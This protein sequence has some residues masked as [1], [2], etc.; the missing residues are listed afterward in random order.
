MKAHKPDLIF[1]LLHSETLPTSSFN[2]CSPDQNITD[3]YFESGRFTLKNLLEVHKQKGAHFQYSFLCELL[4]FLIGVGG[5][6]EDNL[7]W[8]PEMKLENILLTKRGFRVQNPYLDNYYVS[9]QITKVMGPL[10]RLEKNGTLRAGAAQDAQLRYTVERTENN[11]ELSELVYFHKKKIKINLLNSLIMILSLGTLTDE[12][13]F[14]FKYQSENIDHN[15]ANFKT[16]A[17]E[18]HY[19][20]QYLTS[21]LKDIFAIEN[22]NLISTF[23]E[24]FGLEQIENIDIPYID[25]ITAFNMSQYVGDG[26]DRALVGREVRVEGS[27]RGH[28]ERVVEGQGFISRE[29]NMKVKLP[30][31]KEVEKST[32]R[33]TGIGPVGISGRDYDRESPMTKIVKLKEGSSLREED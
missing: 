18:N 7:E 5:F 29:K 6:L 12:E 19:N 13:E 25:Y 1:P 33:G 27:G 21:L 16:K 15:M 14:Y 8:I 28:A 31:G 11:K 32:E 24:L 3:L 17:F 4:S 2:F 10:D 20:N 9:E 23:T 22:L 30:S 26:L